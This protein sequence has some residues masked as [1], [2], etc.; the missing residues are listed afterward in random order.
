M[1]PFA[2]GSSFLM[3]LFGGVHCVL[4]CGG[5]LGALSARLPR[6]SGPQ[7]RAAHLA[8]YNTGRLATYAALGA[9]AGGVGAASTSALPFRSAQVGLRFAAAA[10][11]IG[12]GLYL[13]GMLKGFSG[14]EGAGGRL[15]R[16]FG[17][18][19][20]RLREAR[21]LPAGV[22]LGA[23]W[24]FLPCGLVYAA[25][26]M[27]F[28]SGSAGQGA[29]TLLAFGVGTLPSLLLVGGLAEGVRRLSQSAR[30]RQAAGLL[31]ALSGSVHLA[32]A[33]MQAG[34][35]PGAPPEKAPCCAGHET[36]ERR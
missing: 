33:G 15:F 16:L 5:I 1:S 7:A 30:V 3:G 36:G 20:S 26:A 18:A 19:W 29:L 12:A 28:A 17:P 14:I 31:I 11:M 22:A 8:A 27:A 21:S 4:M 34:W 9:F 2:V 23:L 35:L 25:V 6:A 13:A 32:M 10:V 24:G